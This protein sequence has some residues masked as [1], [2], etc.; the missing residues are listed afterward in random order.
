MNIF[1]VPTLAKKNI[2]FRVISEGTWKLN[3]TFSERELST[4][5]HVCYTLSPFRT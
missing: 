3:M 5:V 4:Y 2:R 1:L